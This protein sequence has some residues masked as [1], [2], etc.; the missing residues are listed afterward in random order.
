MFFAILLFLSWVFLFQEV[1]FWLQWL[2]KKH[3]LNDTEGD[4]EGTENGWA[5]KVSWRFGMVAESEEVLNLLT[6]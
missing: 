6:S 1:A 5:M 2:R 3:E 4:T